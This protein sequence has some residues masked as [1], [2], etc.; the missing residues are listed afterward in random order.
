MTNLI[1]QNM[2][3]L[4]GQRNSIDDAEDARNKYVLRHQMREAIPYFSANE[5]ESGPFKLFCEDF[6]PGNVLVDEE[7]LKI[8]AVIDWEW[9]YTAPRQFLYSP[10][11]WLILE[12]PTSW[13]EYGEEHYQKRLVTFLECLEAVEQKRNLPEEQRMST[14]MRQYA[15]DGTFWIVQLL[16]DAFNFDG[17]V[18]VRNIKK[19][20]ETRGLGD[21]GVPRDDE[22]ERFVMMKMKDLDEYKQD[23]QALERSRSERAEITNAEAASD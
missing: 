6:R 3:H 23:L 11:P 2:K 8:Q 14:Q 20:L 12:R 22:I 21:I 15:E 13:T 10:P 7:T 17:E 19:L 5:V 1:Q 4:H 9:T 16:Q 18:F